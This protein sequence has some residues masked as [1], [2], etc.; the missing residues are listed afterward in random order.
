[1]KKLIPFLLAL[2]LLVSC[3]SEAVSLMDFIGEDS[4]VSYDGRT[5][6]VHCDEDYV[7]AYADD[8][9]L[10]AEAMHK[11]IA[12]IEKKFDID[13][14]LSHTGY[15]DFETYFINNIAS[16]LKTVDLFY[17][18]GN[19]SLWKLANAKVLL[20]MTSFG[21]Y[22]DLN[23]SDKYG[24]PGILEAA[25]ING[26]PY[27]VQPTYWPGLQGVECFVT[28]YNRDML[29][30]MG[31]T[32]L[33]EYYENK[34]WTWDTFKSVLDAASP[35]IPE[36]D[37]LFS[38]RPHYLMNT[39]FYSNGFDYVD[40]IEGV[41]HFNLYSED[42]IHA[43]EFYQSLQQY[44]NQIEY[45]DSHWDND[46]F[47]EGKCLMAMAM[48]QKVIVGDIAYGASFNYNIMPF[49][50]GPDAEYGKWAQTVTRI[51]GL[52]IPITVEEP[53]ISAHM[54]SEL[55]EPFEDFGGSREGLIQYYRDSVFLSPL[56]V[57]IFFDMEQY[58]R[59]DYDDA[60][61][62]FDYTGEIADNIKT[63]SANE[64]IQRY[65]NAAQRI[66]DEYIQPNL[67]GYIIEHMDIE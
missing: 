28:A 41:P 32:D 39:L 36:G 31:L 35:L 47:I 4:G 3:S 59:Y 20:P 66:Y 55:A 33:H 50:M 45:L 26:V 23:D 63:A 27:A 53:E 49:P 48:A 40:I 8:Q 17:R 56:D 9:S 29:I 18:G 44:G 2:I 51:Y 57:E 7:I 34:T 11:R 43:V 52:A 25:M 61:L 24:A 64:L 54:I 46:T 37:I 13:I 58:V 15:D 65:S 60:D 22:I 14:V 67:T 5:F 16:G 6:T 30:G 42:A 12:D 10:Q 38:G 19:N 1:M 21:D 62:L